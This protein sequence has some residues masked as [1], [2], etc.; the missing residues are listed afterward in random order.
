MTS[1]TQISQECLAVHQNKCDLTWICGAGASKALYTMGN[2][3]SFTSSFGVL[4]NNKSIF[5]MNISNTWKHKL[6][7][8][9]ITLNKT[10]ALK[11]SVRFF[12]YSI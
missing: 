6:E 3:W 7:C 4:V 5:C 11:K 12:T 9:P 2:T 1:K 8:K 10:K